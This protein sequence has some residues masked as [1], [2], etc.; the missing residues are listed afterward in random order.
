MRTL[1]SGGTT[2]ETHAL[3]G[4][5]LDALPAHVAVL[6]AGGRIVAVNDAWDRFAC[7]SG[8]DG[9]PTVALGTSYLHVC[10]AATGAEKEDARATAIGIRRLL[11]GEIDKFT[12]EYACYGP[13]EE[14]WFE[15]RVTPIAGVG[16]GRALITHENIT[17]RVVAEHAVQETIAQ[18]TRARGDAER[19]SH[20][21]TQFLSNVSHELRTPLNGVL[22]AVELL[23]SATLEEERREYLEIIETSSRTLVGII[24]NVLD[25]AKIEQGALTLE[26]VPL[27]LRGV[28][29]SAVKGLN[30]CPHRCHRAG[31]RVYA[32]IVGAKSPRI[33][34][35]R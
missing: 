23:S 21:K 26:T 10:D 31:C 4:G 27:S 29:A 8:A 2:D 13:N 12:Y 5:A 3:L 22:G 34:R 19:A 15:L 9:H 20:A 30:M 17:A 33:G 16:L 7:Q 24:N 35:N 25:V 14:F 6:D 28:V 11:A 18:L 1:N 32:R